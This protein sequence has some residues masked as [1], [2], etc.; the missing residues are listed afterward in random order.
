MN[1]ERSGS[2]ENRS[3]QGASESHETFSIMI[4][5]RQVPGANPYV[6][7]RGGAMG[8]QRVKLMSS[9]IATKLDISR[10]DDAS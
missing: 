7:S 3:T 1:E 6:L 9:F 8:L 2:R 4:A 10:T 5:A